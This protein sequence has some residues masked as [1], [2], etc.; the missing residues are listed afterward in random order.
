M[1]KTQSIFSQNL[2]GKY[3]PFIPHFQNLLKESTAIILI[4]DLGQTEP[5]GPNDLIQ[6]LAPHTVLINSNMTQRASSTG[7][8][9]HKDWQITGTIKKHPSGRL[10]GVQVK[11][12]QKIF[13][14]SAYLPWGVG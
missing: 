13:I 11:K 9:L 8:I 7:I 3:K 2:R 4:Q 5:G 6:A 10:T 1:N 12:E 14:M